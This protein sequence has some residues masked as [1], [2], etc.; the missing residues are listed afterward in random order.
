VHGGRVAERA[1][2]SFSCIVCC[3]PDRAERWTTRQRPIESRLRSVPINPINRRSR[4]NG[5][6]KED[7]PRF[8]VEEDS[9]GRSAREGTR[10][11][12]AD[13]DGFQQDRVDRTRG[14]T[15]RRRAEGSEGGACGPFTG[16]ERM[17]AAKPASTKIKTRALKKLK[18]AA[19]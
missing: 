19:L 9:E 4:L 10:R 6:C 8:C 11:A 3:R 18:D 13:Q 2:F 12:Q 14:R 17:F 7:H 5:N 1:L 16:V 15:G